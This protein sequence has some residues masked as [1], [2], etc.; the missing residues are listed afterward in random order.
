MVDNY[1]ITKDK[2]DE[3]M[4]IKDYKTFL[5]KNEQKSK[6]NKK[7]SSKGN[8]DSN[9]INNLLMQMNSLSQKQLSLIDIM[10]NIQ[11]ETQGQINQLNKRISKLEKNVEDLN[12]ELYYLKNEQD[13]NIFIL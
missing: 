2:R 11:M 3:D 9:I 6:I 5:N 4:D 8:Y 1:D 10:D 7:E 12:N 13:K